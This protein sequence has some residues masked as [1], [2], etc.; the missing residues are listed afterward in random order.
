MVASDNFLGFFLPASVRALSNSA[1]PAT[2][3]ISDRLFRSLL[4][5]VWCA[6]CQWLYNVLQLGSWGMRKINLT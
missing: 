4:S 1:H 2:E 5:F 3:K 6:D